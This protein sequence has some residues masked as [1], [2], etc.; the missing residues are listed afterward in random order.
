VNVAILSLDVLRATGEGHEDLFRPFEQRSQ[1]RS[2]L[3]LG[4]AFSGR[5]VEASGGTL[6]VRNHRDHGCVFTIE[7]PLSLG[8]EVCAVRDSSSAVFRG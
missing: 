6:S 3:G 5:V 8:R 1:D 4:L 7:L 2:G